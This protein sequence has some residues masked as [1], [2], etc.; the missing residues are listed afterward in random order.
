MKYLISIKCSKILHSLHCRNG[1]LA[2]I[3]IIQLQLELDRS[4]TLTFT[5]TRELQLCDI[6]FS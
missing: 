5:L 3:T 2:T 1:N 6:Y 4:L